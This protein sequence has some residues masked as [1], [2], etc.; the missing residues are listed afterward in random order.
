[1]ARLT[2]LEYHRVDQLLT[3]DK[4]LPELAPKPEAPKA[5][6]TKRTPIRLATALLLQHPEIYASV[7]DNIPPAD[8][9]T[10]TNQRV[11]RSLL[12]QL[13]TC[14]ESTTAHLLEL[15]RET[16]LFE[17]LNQ[18]AAWEHHV[19]ADNLAAE[20]T[21]TVNF[22]VKQSELRDIEMLIEKAR[23]ETLSEPERQ[24]LQSM[25]KNRHR[26]PQK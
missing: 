3:S 10:E 9:F 26:T 24:V 1:L 12:E 7:E 21:E 15:F 14:P 20:F 25:L 16:P 6:H 4:A 13:H 18:L 5:R 23:H 11:L 2:H 17:A 22:L 8:Q 19:P